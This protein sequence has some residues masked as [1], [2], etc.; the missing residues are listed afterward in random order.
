MKKALKGK[1]KQAVSTEFVD[2]SHEDCDEGDVEENG[3]EDSDWQKWIPEYVTAFATTN[4]GSFK[5]LH[6]NDNSVSYR[7]LNLLSIL[8]KSVALTPHCSDTDIG[9]SS[10]HSEN[11]KGQYIHHKYESSHSVRL[12]EY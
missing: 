3:S 12:F 9:F 8:L 7:F 6:P 5:V 11:H 2:S 1:L 10:A 4:K